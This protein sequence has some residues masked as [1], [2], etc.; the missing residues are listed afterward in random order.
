MIIIFYI[1][2]KKVK[3]TSKIFHIS[4]EIFQINSFKI[5]SRDKMKNTGHFKYVYYCRDL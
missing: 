5:F 1:D 4:F 3:Y 2:D